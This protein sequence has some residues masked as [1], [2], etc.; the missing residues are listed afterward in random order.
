MCVC[1][2]VDAHLI[3][4]AAAL[5]SP[6]LKSFDPADTKGQFLTGN[7]VLQDF[8]EGCGFTLSLISLAWLLTVAS[9]RVTRFIMADSSSMLLGGA[10]EYQE[11]TE[12]CLKHEVSYLIIGV[13]HV[14]FLPF[15]GGICDAEVEASGGSEGWAS[16][17]S[18]SAITSGRNTQSM[19]SHKICHITFHETF[20]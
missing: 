16:E 8:R 4:A 11:G 17:G 18:N 3:H 2:C 14:P 9:R 1:V 10:P 5:Y 7:E 19:S 13:F 15:S 12:K 20:V 6:R